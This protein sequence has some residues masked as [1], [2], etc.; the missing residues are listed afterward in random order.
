[1][2]DNDEI[3]NLTRDC[4]VI[5]VPFGE[6]QI[7]SKGSEIQIMQAM[8]GSYTIYTAEGMFRINGINADAIGKEPE[9][10]P[11]ISDDISDDDFEN[12][13][14]KQMKTVYDPEIPI[15]VVD[16][17]LIYGC[18]IFKDSMDNYQIKV[19]MTLTAPGCGMADVLVEDIKERISL[20]PRIAEV[21]VE[22]VLDPP[23]S[24][25][26]MSEAARLEAGLV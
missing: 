11:V 10:P 7:L 1:M 3:I 25:E 22:L 15:N 8:G 21:Q 5:S 18:S 24:M 17:G 12:E 9:K 4:D 13:V 16:L 2:I 19:D 23:W 20:L 6:K 26:M 14:W